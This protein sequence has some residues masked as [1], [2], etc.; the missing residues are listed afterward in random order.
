[1][2]HDVFVSYSMK[3]KAVAD[4]VCAKLEG[5]KIR[6]WI[7]PRD[8]QG[9][10]FYAESIIDAISESR[11]MVLILSSNSNDS[12]HVTREVE[13]A[14]SGGTVVIPFRIEDV[15]LSKS[16]QYFIGPVH[17]LDA[18]TPPLENHLNQLADSI[19]VLLRRVA[20]GQQPKPAAVTPAPPAPDPQPSPAPPPAAPGPQPWAAPAPQPSPGP[21]P[22]AAP[23][24]QPSP[25]PPPWTAPAP[26]P[27]PGP[28]PWAAPAPQP[29]PSTAL[30][31]AARIAR[32]V[33]NARSRAARAVWFAG[34]GAAAGGLVSLAALMVHSTIDTPLALVAFWLSGAIIAGAVT[35][36]WL[37][38]SRRRPPAAA[39]FG[40]LGGLV[41]GG[42][43]EWAATYA[44]AISSGDAMLWVGS[45]A[46]QW[47]AY[48]WAGAKSIQRG[49]G[50]R[51]GFNVLRRLIGIS[52][53]RF[54]AIGVFRSEWMWV[55]WLHDALLAIG[56][57]LGLAVSG[58]MQPAAS[59][60]IAGEPAQVHGGVA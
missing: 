49:E 44:F 8:A 19:D 24:P 50:A 14:A 38:G 34:F 21:Q 23:A 2:A 58:S 57:R 35:W 7:A 1:M 40:T 29:A 42:V 55:L 54:L 6:C 10:V 26:Q 48:G 20:S 28:Q 39:L 13:R 30:P 27:S 37:Y 51:L 43:V 5:R 41:I 25:G 11:F 16:L 56:W 18:L 53:I 4:A 60:S 36:C 59:P 33:F 22:W 45:S 52:M 17:W 32:G 46:V 9:G 47:G 3:D 12:A 15:S 31:V